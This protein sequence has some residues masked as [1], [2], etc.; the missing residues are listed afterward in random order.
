M[1]AF[2]LKKNLKFNLI[3][4]V[5]VII[6]GLNFL[7]TYWND[8]YGCFGTA[9][10]YYLPGRKTASGKLYDKYK[11]T[12]AHRKIPFGTKVKVSN[13]ENR[14]EVLVEINDR[15]PFVNG[16]II[17]LSWRAANQLGILKQGIARVKITIIP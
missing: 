1:R 9:S 4:K 15:G 14:R 5:V 13:L 6:I 12:A 7:Y 8:R 2:W 10:Y 11:L 3:I 17:D 16:R